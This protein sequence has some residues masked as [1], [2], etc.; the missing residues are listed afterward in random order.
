MIEDNGCQIDKQYQ[1]NLF[2][3]H[4]D[5]IDANDK[6]TLHLNSY[7][8]LILTYHFLNKILVALYFVNSY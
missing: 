2:F 7:I 8:I 5:T 1:A 6:M 4:I 3:S